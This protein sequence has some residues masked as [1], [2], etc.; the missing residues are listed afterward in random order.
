MSN[1][2]FVAL[3]VSRATGNVESLE[4]TE[5][6]SQAHCQSMAQLVQLMNSEGPPPGYELKLQCGSRLALESVIKESNCRV[7]DQS[8]SDLG[9]SVSTYTCEPGWAVKLENWIRSI[10][11]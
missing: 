11:N 6:V 1:L 2:Y 3:L 10:L 5:I 4:A 7:I 8:R 9:Q